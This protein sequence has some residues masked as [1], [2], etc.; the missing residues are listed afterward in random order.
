[1]KSGV[2]RCFGVW[3]SAVW[4]EA[5]WEALVD[6]LGE[7]AAARGV[8]L[9]T[10]EGGSRD[11]EAVRRDDRR[12]WTGDGGTDDRAVLAALARR[13]FGPEATGVLGWV[14]CPARRDR[15]VLTAGPTVS[16]GV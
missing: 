11:T 9:I 3:S 4:L 15:R 13:V 8:L 5:T 6:V 16:G 14:F 10:G 12:S 2:R 7:R 1:M